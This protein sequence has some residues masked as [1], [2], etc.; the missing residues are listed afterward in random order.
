MN[1]D[2]IICDLF[3]A[4]KF[5]R[6]FYRSQFQH[7]VKIFTYLWWIWTYIKLEVP[8]SFIQSN[9]RHNWK[10]F[11]PTACM[12]EHLLNL[13]LL[14]K[15]LSDSLLAVSHWASLTNSSGIL[16]SC[17]IRMCLIIMS[18]YCANYYKCIITVNMKH[19]NCSLIAE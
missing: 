14:C 18:T 4:Y 9:W 8:A 17:L 2:Y 7:R 5:Y 1:Y 12:K 16:H 11:L 13:P 19:I 6:C 3:K 15:K 10:Q